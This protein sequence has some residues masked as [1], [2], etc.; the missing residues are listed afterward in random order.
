MG[1]FNPNLAP[2]FANYIFK[3]IN[4]VGIIYKVTWVLEYC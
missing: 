3:T 1:W 4:H 2:I